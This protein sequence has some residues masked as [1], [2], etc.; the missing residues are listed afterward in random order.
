[1]I[2]FKKR[3][4]R[5]F[6]PMFSKAGNKL[7]SVQW[8]VIDDIKVKISRVDKMGAVDYNCCK[9]P[10]DNINCFIILLCFII[11]HICAHDHRKT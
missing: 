11:E 2:V 1:M 8:N 10:L 3:V 4:G 7:N 9:H 6:H 5:A